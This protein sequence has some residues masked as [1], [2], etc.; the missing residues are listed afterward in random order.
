MTP[1]LVVGNEEKGDE[2]HTHVQ[3]PE[4]GGVH[5]LDFPETRR[6]KDD[7]T[8]TDLVETKE[9]AFYVCGEDSYLAGVGGQYVRGLKEAENVAK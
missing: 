8:W 1:F 9:V 5:K 2:Y 3:C 7:G 4:C 6:L